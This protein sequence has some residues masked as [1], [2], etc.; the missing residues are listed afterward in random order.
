MSCKDGFDSHSEDEI[1]PSGDK[2]T[3]NSMFNSYSKP[4]KD[5]VKWMLESDPAY[6]PSVQDLLELAIFDKQVIHSYVGKASMK[7]KL[8][9]DDDSESYDSLFAYTKALHLAEVDSY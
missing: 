4:V 6:R 9:I 3:Y 5:V 7:F 2:L 1:D 8:N